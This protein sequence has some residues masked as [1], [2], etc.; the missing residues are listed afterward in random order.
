MTSSPY[1]GH[2]LHLQHHHY[3][4]LTSTSNQR[5]S[6]SR[7]NSDV[8]NNKLFSSYDEKRRL[9]ACSSCSGANS[10]NKSTSSTASTTS[11]RNSFS[12]PSTPTTPPLNSNEDNL[13]FN[14]SRSSRGEIDLCK[15]VDDSVE[16]DV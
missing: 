15:R 1:H 3:Q 10:Q 16:T 11:F 12:Q 6:T 9:S 2:S 4:Q 7:K 8:T 5:I 14:D 13:P